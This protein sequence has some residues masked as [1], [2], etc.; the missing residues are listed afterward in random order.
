MEPMDARHHRKGIGR[1]SFQSTLTLP[2][3][4]YWKRG[5]ALGCF[6]QPEIG[7][8]S[9]QRRIQGIVLDALPTQIAK[10]VRRRW[11][12]KAADLDIR[13]FLQRIRKLLE[14]VWD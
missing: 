12:L 8:R 3:K 1:H 5:K 13:R 4:R 10:P 2:R 6:V 14:E 7:A 9:R 11:R